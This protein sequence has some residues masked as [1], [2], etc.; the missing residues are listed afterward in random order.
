MEVLDFERAEV[1]V[2]VVSVESGLWWA[3]KFPNKTYFIL[4]VLPN[5][6]QTSGCLCEPSTAGFEVKEPSVNL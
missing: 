6:H 2:F 5:P 4:N 1:S 3:C